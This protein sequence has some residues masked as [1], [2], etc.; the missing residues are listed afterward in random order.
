LHAV[1]EMVETTYRV[2]PPE[3]SI[4]EGASNRLKV[5]W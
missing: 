1:I 4:Q 5:L 3:S 2:D